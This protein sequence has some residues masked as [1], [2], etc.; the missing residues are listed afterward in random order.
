MSSYKYSFVFRILI[1]IEANTQINYNLILK[2][3]LKC[4]F[5]D[6]LLRLM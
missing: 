6:Y 3:Y 5:I 2:K 4:L 1:K